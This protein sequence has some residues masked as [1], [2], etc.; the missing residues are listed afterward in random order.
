MRNPKCGELAPPHPRR[1]TKGRT[2]TYI[3]RVRTVNNS[4]IG[5]FLKRLSGSIRHEATNRQKQ[6]SRGDLRSARTPA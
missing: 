3:C 6:P 4:G 2:S 5:D 1:L